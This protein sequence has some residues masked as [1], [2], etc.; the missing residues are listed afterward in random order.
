MVEV[1]DLLWVG[2][3]G[4]NDEGELVWVLQLCKIESNN[5]KLKSKQNVTFMFGTDCF[6]QIVVF[7]FMN[8]YFMIFSFG[9]SSKFT[10]SF[11]IL[12]G[13]KCKWST[14]KCSCTNKCKCSK[15]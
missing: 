1:V 14:N 9:S 3:V 6:C 10:V 7:Y 15:A 11:P 5:L 13:T 8:F 4:N 12:F 2:S